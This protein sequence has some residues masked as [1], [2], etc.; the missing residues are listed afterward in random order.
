MSKN[1]PIQIESIVLLLKELLQLRKQ[2]D[3]AKGACSKQEYLI[4]QEY[5]KQATG[6]NVNYDRSIAKKMLIIIDEIP[7]ELAFNYEGRLE[8]F[9]KL[10]DLVFT[11]IFKSN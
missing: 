9:S 4:Q 2:L 1:N 10:E 3:A 11:G 7:Y 8:S 5:T 6:N